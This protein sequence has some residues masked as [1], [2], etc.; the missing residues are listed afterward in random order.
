MINAIFSTL[1]FQVSLFWSVIFL[2]E[3]RTADPAKRLLTIFMLICTLLHF[4]HAAYFNK[5]VQLFSFL[6]SIYTFC[7]L[8][9]Y[10]LYYLYIRK[11]T[12][13]TPLRIRDY[14]VLLPALL[15][16]LTAAVLYIMMGNERVP[17]VESC[18]YKHD[19]SEVTHSAVAQAQYSRLLVMKIV[20]AI[21]LIPVCYFGSK[22]IVAFNKR[23][24]N[25]YANTEEKTLDP[26]RLLLIIFIIFTLLSGTANYIGRDFFIQESW[27]VI[28]PSVI[29]ST[30]IF[31]VAYVGFKQKFT[32]IDFCH[33]EQTTAEKDEATTVA[34]NII[35]NGRNG[36]I[37]KAT[38]PEYLLLGETIGRIIESQQLFR[39]KGLLITD[40]AKLAGSNRTYISTYLN[41]E[42]N[43]SFS[44]FIN[45][46]RVEYAKSLLASKDPV[47]SIPEIFEMSGFTNEVSFY[48][49]FKKH[50]GLTPK[51][52]VKQ[53]GNK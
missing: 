45:N 42:L 21:Q 36:S 20:Y 24:K 4:S 41:Q 25:F 34:E 32:A 48:R 7:T 27:M 43:T 3:Y 5:S 51:Q 14:W 6:E 18:F 13:A 9:G 44:D 35:N 10:P 2:K 33:D 46:Y 29:F 50:T 28:I 31:A 11:L 12:D 52:W 22:R 39:Q 38:N 47:Y 19:A 40:V 30:M 17:F 15:I 8:A 53:Q 37:A 23:V 16:S 26:I 49:I 1:T